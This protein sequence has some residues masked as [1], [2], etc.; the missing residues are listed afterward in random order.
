MT[1]PTSLLAIAASA[2]VVA[3]TN[4]GAGT[5]QVGWW[6]FRYDLHHAVLS[7]RGLPQEPDLLVAAA[8]LLML[9]LPIA[10]AGTLIWWAVT[11]HR[12]PLGSIARAAAGRCRRC[13]WCSS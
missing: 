11:R 8:P 1:R 2:G 5:D 13:P 3:L 6:R 7:T 9:G 10:Q 4:T 12:R